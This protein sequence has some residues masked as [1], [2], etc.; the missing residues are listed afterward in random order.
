M[1]QLVRTS[2]PRNLPF[3]SRW[4]NKRNGYGK[5]RRRNVCGGVKT[6]PSLEGWGPGP[7]FKND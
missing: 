6:N 7:L 2:V 4:D 5:M 1:P 3:V